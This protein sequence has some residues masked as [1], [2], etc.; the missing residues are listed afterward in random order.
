MPQAP[1]HPRLRP[2]DYSGGGYPQRSYELVDRRRPVLLAVA[3]LAPLIAA[4]ASPS[5]T[6]KPTAAT[7]PTLPPSTPSASVP[8]VPSAPN[9]QDQATV[10]AIALTAAELSPFSV[11]API[12]AVP[13][14]APSGWT[15]IADEPLDFAHQ[16]S[17]GCL[18]VLSPYT[19]G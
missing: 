14:A 9:A 11:H 4:C 2:G 16:T 5:T 1:G 6:A 19:A 10:Q 13:G 8:A 18:Q 12:A 15:M 3:V 17:P 7:S